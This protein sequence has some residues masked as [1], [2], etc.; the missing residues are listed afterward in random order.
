MGMKSFVHLNQ[1][2]YI[3]LHKIPLYQI[4]FKTRR[5]KEKNL[6]L[7]T[8][9]NPIYKHAQ[10]ENMCKINDE[11]FITTSGKIFFKGQVYELEDCE[12]LEG[13]KVVIHYSEKRIEKLLKKDSKIKMIP[14]QFIYQKEEDMFLYPEDSM[15]IAQADAPSPAQTQSLVELPP[16]IGQFQELM[17]ITKDNT[18]LALI[19]LVALMFQKMQKKEREDKDH[20]L[21]CDFERQEIGKKINLLESKIDAQAKDQTRILIGDNELADRLNR[22]EDKIKKINLSL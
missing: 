16:E 12:F 1:L 11:F 10:G 9:S 13:S 5:R 17:K 8:Q 2:T 14:D 4:K 19:I 20:A 22:V 21:V 3:L 6:H 7:E 18:P 15:L